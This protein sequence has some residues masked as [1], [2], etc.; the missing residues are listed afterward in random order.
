MNMLIQVAPYVTWGAVSL[1]TVR[2]LMY[3]RGYVSI[4]KQRIPI[5]N[6]LIIAD[7]LGKHGIFC[8]EDLVHEIVTCGPHF[9]L[10]SRFLKPFKLSTPSGGWKGKKRFYNEG[11]DA[12][13]RKDMNSLLQKMI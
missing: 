11:G 2:D 6:N 7:K 13:D 12:G 1:K 9:K 5:T 4:N 8:I 3:K 10:V